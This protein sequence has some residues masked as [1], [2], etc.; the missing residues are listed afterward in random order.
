MKN[1]HTIFLFSAL[2]ILLGQQSRAQDVICIGSVTSISITDFGVKD[3]NFQSKWNEYLQNRTWKWAS[4]H[5]TVTKE[6]I[7][8]YIRY[9]PSD[10]IHQELYSVVEIIK[11]ETLE[12]GRK[13]ITLNLKS[14]SGDNFFPSYFLYDDKD[15]ILTISGI[16]LIATWKGTTL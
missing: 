16:D 7:R 5:I 2:I 1:T 4:G 8:L 3:P 11:N 6:S 13:G 14:L 12:N 9:Q 15:W 10:E